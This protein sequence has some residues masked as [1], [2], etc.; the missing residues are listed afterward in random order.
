MY[1]ERFRSG[2]QPGVVN[3][4]PIWGRVPIHKEVEEVF[5]MWV[6]LEQPG[7]Q[8]GQSRHTRRKV[9]YIE[10]FQ[11]N[12]INVSGRIV[13]N[14]SWPAAV[15][16]AACAN[17]YVIIRAISSTHKVHFPCNPGEWKNS[18]YKQTPDPSA[19]RSGLVKGLSS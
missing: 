18:M 11:W 19:W 4:W 2:R 3:P 12:A 1:R 9:L 14:I 5:A 16:T 7:S 8:T 10:L 13:H 17:Y 15:A 6:N